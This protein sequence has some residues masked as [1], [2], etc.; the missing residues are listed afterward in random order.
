M[1][2][3]LE[4]FGF[5]ASN[6]GL[7]FLGLLV[8]VMI[9]LWDWR[10]TVLGL[11][12]VQIGVAAITVN[13]HG[14]PAQWGAIQVLVTAL[15]SMVLAL[16]TFRAQRAPS[17]HQ[18][19]TWLMRLMVTLLFYAIWRVAGSAV[20]L[21]QIHPG[22]TQLLVWL[23]LCTILMLGLG[24]SPLH[25]GAALVMWLLM[26]QA[27]VT[28]LLANPILVAMIGAIQLLLVLACSYLIVLERLRKVDVPVVLTDIT[29]PEE[30]TFEPLMPPAPRVDDR[31][32]VS[33]SLR[34]LQAFSPKTVSAE[35]LKKN[36]VQPAVPLVSV[37][38]SD[39]Q[40]VQPRRQPLPRR[41]L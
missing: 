12:V 3:I 11:V 24:E 25:V 4:P 32:I 7:A 17:L 5:L 41:K 38:P 28:V 10:V 8:A 6:S 39:E 33:S 13:W 37:E 29:F 34:W 35:D 21:P 23:A 31:G 9:I 36:E 18:A 30:W 16:S 26:V 27:L 2:W 22:L 14:V 15:S 1:T 19:G 20:P 40:T